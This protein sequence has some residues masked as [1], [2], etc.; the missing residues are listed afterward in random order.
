[1]TRRSVAGAASVDSPPLDFGRGRSHFRLDRGVRCLI[2]SGGL[3]MVPYH[4]RTLPC[5]SECSALPESCSLHQSRRA[6]RLNFCPPM[7]RASTRR[8]LQSVA[9][10]SAAGLS[11]ARQRT[12]SPGHGCNWSAATPGHR[13][14]RTRLAPSRLTTLPA[15][16]Y[17]L[18]VDRPGYQPSTY[19][20]R[21]RAIRSV[22][23]RLILEADQ[24]LKGI[25]VPLYRGGVI[26]GRIT[27][28][29][30]RAAR[31][32]GGARNQSHGSWRRGERRRCRCQCDE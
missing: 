18:A 26:A 7:C 27:G 6:G 15:G 9:A 30:W 23:T 5:E 29:A 21:G 19:P 13:S 10:A 22:T 17:T 12:P 28:R 4:P 3:R 14:P 31:V 16:S 8:R 24:V 2:S 32:G 20:A 1:M 11:T 25:S